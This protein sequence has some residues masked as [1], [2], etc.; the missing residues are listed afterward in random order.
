M[1]YEVK[2]MARTKMIAR[3]V[4][5]QRRQAARQAARARAKPA[6]AVI[7][8]RQQIG[9]KNIEG[10]ICNRTFKIKRLLA[11]PKNVCVKKSGVVVPKMV[12]R[13]RAI[14]QAEVRRAYY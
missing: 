4:H 7:P 1:F 5:D 12:V 11:Q 10:R 3:M 2:K 14:F 8:T 6:T 9:V 13:R